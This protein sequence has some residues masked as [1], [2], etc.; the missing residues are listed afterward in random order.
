MILNKVLKTKEIK[1]PN[2]EIMKEDRMKDEKR[3]KIGQYRKKVKLPMQSLSFFPFNVTINLLI[4]SRR[5]RF[6]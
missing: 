1:F 3:E 5:K 6:G 2:L 4:D